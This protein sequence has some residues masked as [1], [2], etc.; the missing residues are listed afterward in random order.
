[1]DDSRSL[2]GGTKMSAGQNRP[3][4]KAIYANYTLTDGAVAD[5]DLSR[6]VRSCG[7]QAIFSPDE[8]YWIAE[9]LDR[10]DT[11][12]LDN[13]EL[14]HR[15]EN[16]VPLVLSV[17]KLTEESSTTVAEF[18]EALEGRLRAIANAEATTRKGAQHCSLEELV[19]LE[20]APYCRSNQF[21]LIGPPLGL[22]SKIAHSFSIIIHELTTNA[23]KHGALSCP[24]GRVLVRWDV[25]SSNGAHASLSL[26]WLERDGPRV[27]GG[28]KRGFGTTI[29]CDE[30]KAITGGTATLVLAPEGLEYALI[31][32]LEG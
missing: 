5:I 2:R 6:Y 30:G 8:L 11:L 25:V 1:M 24:T 31:T 17:I 21:D 18:R 19:R 29:L 9:R 23:V 10:L 14:H 7:E 4:E 27:A 20:L 13:K 32:G 12:Q 16:F 22:P 28:S 26:E 3:L 15:L